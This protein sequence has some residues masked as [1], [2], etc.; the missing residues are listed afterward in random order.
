MLTEE[1][2]ENLP[3]DPDVALAMIADLLAQQSGPE[4]M[5][6]EGLSIRDANAW[7]A[8]IQA[9]LIAH[10]LTERYPK[11]DCGTPPGDSGIFWEWWNRYLADLRQYRTLIYMVRKRNGS[12]VVLPPARKA[13][14]HAL[15]NQIREIVERLNLSE[16]KRN[17]IYRLIAKLQSEVDQTRTGVQTV[18]NL[19]LESSRVLKEVGENA[20]PLVD[21][22]KEVFGIFADADSGNTGPAVGHDDIPKIEN[23]SARPKAR[24]GKAELDD[25]IPF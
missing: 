21:R 17:M 23:K 3:D 5:H 4:E 2:I 11:L 16:T 13:D 14:I 19:V 20:K 9:H 1:D 6:N 24:G 8:D 10:G 7:Y 18:L 22:V 15:L 25:D 12:T